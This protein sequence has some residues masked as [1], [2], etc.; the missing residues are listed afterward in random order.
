MT[1][2]HTSPSD[3]ADARAPSASAAAVSPPTS[4][5]GL[6]PTASTPAIRS[7]AGSPGDPDPSASSAPPELDFA[8]TTALVI[9]A[10]ASGRAAAELLVFLGARVRL[11]DQNPDATV[12]AGVEPVLGAAELP[13]EAFA[14]LGLMILSPGVPPARFRDAQRRWAPQARVHGEMSLSLAIAAARFGRLPT[15]LITGTNGK[16]TVTALTGALLEAGGLKPFVG[17]NL[18]VPLAAALLGLL[19]ARAP[20][21]DALVLE[22]SSFQLETLE[23]A[24]TDVAMVLNIT[25]D[26]LDRYPGLDDYAATKAR[27]F[28]GLGPDGLA[29]LDAGDGF[30]SFLR[31]R[32]GAGRLVLVDDPDGARLL[33][34]GPGDS[35]VLPDGETFA[36]RALPI[37][38]RHNS[39][40]ALFAL[41]AARRLGVDH[42]ACV[43]GLEG[44]HGLPH[45]M[46]FVRERAGVRFYDDSK[47]TNVAS[48]L[49]SLDGFDRPVVLIAGGRAKGDDLTPLRALLG[50][51]G[52]ALVAIGESADAFY[53]LADGLVPARRANSMAEAVELAAALAGPGDAVV[54]SPACASYDWFKN[55]GER[56]DTFARLVRALPAE[57]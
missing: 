30:T 52:R 14:G 56:G 15:V 24:A 44:F 29:L 35:L 13:A 12:P 38:G 28:T 27:V 36:R 17:G 49:A 7:A 3:P 25:P 57:K 43:R 21:P 4:A 40:N 45:R 47:A 5:S 6:D 51:S 41:L 9:G 26:H 18:G 37:P 50:R 23:H 54:L 19:R 10:G 55:Y 31:A 22:C 2:D 53:P 1:A 16:S 11:Y 8:R 42:D 39:K 33:G 20:A 32:V 46:T 48:V 34:P